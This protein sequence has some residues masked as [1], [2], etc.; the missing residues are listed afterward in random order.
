MTTYYWYTYTNVP[1]I[2]D[3]IYLNIKYGHNRIMICI[4][5]LVVRIVCWPRMSLG[6]RLHALLMQKLILITSAEVY[7]IIIYWMNLAYVCLCVCS[8]WGRWRGW[9]H[10]LRHRISP[11]RSAHQ[12]RV[13]PKICAISIMNITYLVLLANADDCTMPDRPLPVQ[14]ASIPLIFRQTATTLLLYQKQFK[15]VV[16]IRM[17]SHRTGCS[18]L[19]CDNGSAW[20]WWW[21]VVYTKS[22]NASSL[23]P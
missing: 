5:K 9:Q 20:W 18:A 2:C 22:P 15:M 6:K 14:R 16:S 8:W 10:G 3:I 4:R 23:Y 11:S 21:F 13:C 12:L 17:D 19:W 7:C 1:Y